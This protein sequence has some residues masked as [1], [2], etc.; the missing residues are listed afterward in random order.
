MKLMHFTAEWCQ[1]C[2]MMKPIIDGVVADNPEID[3]HMIDIDQNQG[4]ALDF[5]IMSVPTFILFDDEDNITARV[6]G[7]MMR[8][9]FEKAL[10]L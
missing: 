4:T 1:P 6:T 7:A 3:Y 10:G 2:K 5:E 9:Q 8:G